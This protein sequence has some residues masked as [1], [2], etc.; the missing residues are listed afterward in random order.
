MVNQGAWVSEQ[1]INRNIS[2]VNC[3]R[4][5]HCKNSIYR[6]ACVRCVHNKSGLHMGDYYKEKIP[7]IKYL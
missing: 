5:G 1:D 2:N 6:Q 7:G 3:R 4:I